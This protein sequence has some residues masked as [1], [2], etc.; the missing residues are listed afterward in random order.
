MFPSYIDSRIYNIYL[1][2]QFKPREKT[3]FPTKIR[4]IL[5]VVRLRCVY[6]VRKYLLRRHVSSRGTLRHVISRRNRQFFPRNIHV[7]TIQ[8]L[9]KYILQIRAYVISF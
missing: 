4:F 7:R 3:I 5:K 9:F 6:T 2:N 1:I 8:R